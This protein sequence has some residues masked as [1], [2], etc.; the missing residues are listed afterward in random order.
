MDA[1]SEQINNLS[2]QAAIAMLELVLSRTGHAPDPFATDNPDDQRRQALGQPDLPSCGP[3]L[4]KPPSDGDLAR[5]TLLYLTE[6][7]ASF[8]D[9]ITPIVSRSPEFGEPFTRD[10]GAF[11]LGALV[12]LALHTDLELRK[13]PGKGWYF[14]F[15]IKP[16]PP[17]PSARCSICCTPNTSASAAVQSSMPIPCPLVADESG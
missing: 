6:R 12:L 13:Q 10:A 14:H 5:A 7:D 4:T 1:L 11:A 3:P 8:R 16:L 17:Q 15:K 9:A 2:D